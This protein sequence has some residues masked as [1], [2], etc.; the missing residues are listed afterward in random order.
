MIL[1]NEDL[2]DA[3]K[4]LIKKMCIK[5]LASLK[6]LYEGKSKTNKDI[7]LLLAQNE[8]S[9]EEFQLALETE[10]IKFQ[11]FKSDPN[12]VNQ[13]DETQVRIFKHMLENLPDK[14]KRDYPLAIN[15]LWTRIK[16]MEQFSTITM[17]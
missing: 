12:I 8:I 11:S 14:Y 13:L 3:Q 6:R 10:A 15:N 17:N 4:F 1:F 9:E 2:T 5:Q 16:L 7:E